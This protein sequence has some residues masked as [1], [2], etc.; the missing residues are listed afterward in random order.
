MLVKLRSTKDKGKV[1][2]N[3]KNLK[4][5]KNSKD[6]SYY[7]NNQMIPC[8]Q[9]QHRWY[10]QLVKHNKNLTGI[11]QHNLTFKEGELFVDG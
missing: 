8:L 1:F 2:E 7:V 11:A 3:V 9:E 4:D 6:G 10:R 5:E